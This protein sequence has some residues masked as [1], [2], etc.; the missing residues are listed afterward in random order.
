MVSCGY[1]GGDMSGLARVATAPVDACGGNPPSRG[2]R[3]QFLRTFRTPRRDAATFVWSAA[4]RRSSAG[5]T[6]ACTSSAAR[7]RKPSASAAER[8]GKRASC[9]T[10]ERAPSPPSATSRVTAG[11]AATAAGSASR[12]AASASRAT[13]APCSL[14]WIITTWRGVTRA[15][16]R[17]SAKPGARCRV[18]ANSSTAAPTPAGSDEATTTT[19]AAGQAKLSCDACAKVASSAVRHRRVHAP[20]SRRAQREASAVS[21]RESSSTVVS[22][23]SSSRSDTAAAN[24]VSSS[25]AGA[26]TMSPAARNRTLRPPGKL[27]RLDAE[28]KANGPVAASATYAASRSR[29][30]KPASRL[31]TRLASEVSTQQTTGPTPARNS[32]WF[33]EGGRAL[34]ALMG[35]I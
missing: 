28:R 13:L 17:P 4:T 25:A 27:R 9:G 24:L 10:S 29:R 8:R 3:S 30:P 1:W 35:S 22:T 5:T 2:R 23:C 12:A 7:R 31:T 32:S 21:A 34:V 16:Y 26:D 11:A 6:T 20:A 18:D 33:V 19:T 15:S 14:S